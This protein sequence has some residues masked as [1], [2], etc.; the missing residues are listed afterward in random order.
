MSDLVELKI[1]GTKSPV[2]NEQSACPSYYIKY[3]DTKVILDCGSGSHRFF[4]FNDLSGLNIFIS[5]FHYDHYTDLYN[6]MYAS[7]VQKKQNRIE[8]PINIYIPTY[9]YSIYES[10][11]VENLTYSNL[12]DINEYSSY[13]LDN[14]VKVD[15]CKLVHSK[16]IENYAIR[17]RI[18]NKTIVYTGDLS[19]DAKNE[20]V[21]FAKNADILICESTLLKEY[22]FP[23]IN[24]H[25]TAYQAATI[26]KEA[27][28][29][30]LIL[31]HFNIEEK[32]EKYLMEAKPVFNNTFL[33]KEKESYLI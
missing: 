4:N 24:I 23:E 31:T 29:K 26:A 19:F 27:N 25:L 21:N 1:L 12:Y 28:V 8:K 22:N 5:H 13:N 3:K 33:A 20:I 32:T 2:C 17:V 15:F 11:K 30:K 18:G 10:I 7:Y 14:D 9:P 16:F 6:Y